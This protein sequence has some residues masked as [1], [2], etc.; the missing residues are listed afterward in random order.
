MPKSNLDV[1]QQIHNIRDPRIT[2]LQD[3]LFSEKEIELSIL[4]LDEV[5]PEISG[6]KFYK[7]I[8]FL[9][10]AGKSSHKTIIT[11]GGAYSNHLAATAFACKEAGIKSIG[12]VRG[13]K[14][15]TLSPTL[16]FCINQGM[17]LKFISRSDYK[18]I[19]DHIFLRE[20]ENIYGEHILIPEGGYSEKGANG[21]SLITG[22]FTKSYS[23]ICLAVGTA[24]TFAGMINGVDHGSKILGFDILK[25]RNDLKD[26]LKYLKADENADY[27]LIS[28][29]HFG[30]YA[31]KTNELLEFMNE[32]YR[33]HAIPLDFVYTGKMMFGLYDIIS[34]NYFPKGSKIL[35]IHTGGLQGNNSLPK[36]TLIY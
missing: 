33:K 30:G 23:H 9:E 12:I 31:K 18:S 17:D 28:D 32:F 1:F 2:I 8:Y 34:K 25:N 5:H 10:E 16:S 22:Y 7:L 6:N 19:S 35:C 29:Y 26:R 14:P 36:N 20:L 21:A 27:E 13:E 4:R 11:F 3:T 24:T 15:L